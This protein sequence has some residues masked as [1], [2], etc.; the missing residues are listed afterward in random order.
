MSFLILIDSRDKADVVAWLSQYPNLKYI[1]KDG[2][3]TY[4]SAIREAHPDAHHISDWFY[5]LKN[6]TDAITQCIY[7]ILSGRIV[8]P[9]TR[10]NKVM[11]E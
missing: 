8:I 2:S 4:A 6:L 9:L 1:S 3:P 11:N 10:E 5:L 7:K